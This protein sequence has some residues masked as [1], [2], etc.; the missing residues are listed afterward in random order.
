MLITL[1]FKKMAISFAENLEKPAKNSDHNIDPRGPIRKIRFGA[2]HIVKFCSIG[3][4]EKTGAKK[5]ALP[6]SIFSNT[7]CAISEF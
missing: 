6:D 1:V 2:S 7:I 4:R 3:W 5:F